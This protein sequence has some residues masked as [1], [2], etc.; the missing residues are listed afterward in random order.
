MKHHDRLTRFVLLLAL[1]TTQV[2]EA[3]NAS[4]REQENSKDNVEAKDLSRYD[5][6]VPRDG[7]LRVAIETANAQEDTLRRFRIFVC[8]GEHVIP[9]QGTIMGGDSVM[10][11]DPRLHL[12]RPRVS[13]IGEDRDAT[14]ATNICPP[15]TWH[16]GF[17]PSS[18]L[19]GIG[20]GDVL[21]IEA[22]AHDTY[23]QDITLKSGMGDR[24]GRNVVLHDRSTRT[25]CNNVC[26]WAYQDTYVSDNRQGVFYFKG[27]V[28]RGRTDYICG[29]GD[30]FF[31]HVTFQQCGTGGYICAPSVPLEYGYVMDHCYI[32]AETPDVT[33]YLGRPWGSATPTAYWINTQVDKEPITHD[34]KG[35]NGWADMGSKGWPARFCEYATHLNDGTLLDLTGRRSIY[36]DKDGN[37]HPNN[38]ILTKEEA[39]AITRDKVLHQWQPVFDLWK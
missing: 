6:V 30:V 34:K 14:V 4:W 38:P 35:Y 10:Y 36:T 37:E 23:L 5:F 22:S 19:E 27:G 11:P 16:N 2:A 28:L 32:K 39:E 12:T 24:T 18:P 25:I 9:T 3:A 20:N 8:K 26:L 33:Y 31:D 21:I 1:L 29:K 7:D 13:L 17:N 15:P